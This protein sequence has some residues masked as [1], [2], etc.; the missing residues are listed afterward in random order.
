MS[1][2]LVGFLLILVGS[3]LN[4]CDGLFDTWRNSSARQV[5]TALLG[6]RGISLT[7]STRTPAQSQ[8][9]LA[10]LNQMFGNPNTI[11]SL[12]QH[13]DLRQ[14]LHHVSAQC[15]ARQ[16]SKQLCLRIELY[17]GITTYHCLSLLLLS[18]LFMP[19]A[20]GTTSTSQ[21]YYTYILHSQ[22]RNGWIPGPVA[23]R[24]FL[25]RKLA[26]QDATLVMPL[27]SDRVLAGVFDGHGE[28]G[29]ARGNCGW[30]RLVEPGFCMAC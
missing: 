26:M 13:K 19:I 7:G 25:R 23:R 30:F 21:I 16:P 2:L 27:G 8:P 28:Q 11:M 4:E 18:L 3:Q 29:A 10:S 1:C 5:L 9:G 24:F 17:A 6:R 14:G 20:I 12:A 22:P 15:Y